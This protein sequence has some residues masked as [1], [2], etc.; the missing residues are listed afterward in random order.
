MKGLQQQDMC[1]AGCHMLDMHGAL[2][3]LALA[4]YCTL[5]WYTPVM[6]TLVYWY[7]VLLGLGWLSCWIGW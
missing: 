4:L 7:L 3:L 5:S 1:L 6:A 2:F